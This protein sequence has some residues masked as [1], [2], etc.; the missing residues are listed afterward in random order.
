MDFQSFLTVT[1]GGC[2]E[3]ADSCRMVH[4][5]S[6]VPHRSSPWTKTTVPMVLGFTKNSRSLR[7]HEEGS[8][9]QRSIKGSGLQI[10]SIW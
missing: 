3:S 4:F 5:S 9:Q 8:R 1:A 7:D 6:Q 2:R 10:A